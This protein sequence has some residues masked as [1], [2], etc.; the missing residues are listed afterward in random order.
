M[1]TVLVTGCNGTVGR[2]VTKALL[3]GGHRVVGVSL[4]D[5]CAL[6]HA[7]LGYRTLDITDYNATRQLLQE[8]TFDALVH[9]A[10]LVHVP[11]RHLG[12]ADYN[13][14]NYRA[15]EHLFR[16]AARQGIRRMLI[17]STIE[18]YG[19]TPSHQAVNEDAPC[20]PESDYA[21]TKLLAEEALA[22]VAEESSSSYA[23]L[24]LAPVYA[25]DFRVNLDKR[26]YLRA[27]VGYYLSKGDYQLGLC[28]AHN[29]AH[30]V[31]RW[32]E[33]ENPNSGIFNVADGRI[34]PI[35]ELLE[36]ERQAGRC[37]ITLRLPYAPC[38]AGVA[39]LQTILTIIGR[40]PGMVT[41][42]NLRKLVR[43][44]EWDTHRAQ[45][46]VGALPWTLDNTSG[47]D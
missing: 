27:P 31:T 1:I 3:D 15:S 32:L 44:T 37:K 29:V 28:S 39:A 40:Q 26:L 38:L 23:I 46:V 42:D 41:V 10:A 22:Q 19:Q 16:Q 14:V 13:R 36:R 30:F 17:A 12:F 7:E 9:L 6:S 33:L 25:S 11:S 2:H 21:R 4:E 35:K 45:S 24:R 34:Y 5:R 43:S 8:W 18:V 47:L 20:H